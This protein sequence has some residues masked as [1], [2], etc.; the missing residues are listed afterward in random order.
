V[1]SAFKALLSVFFA[2]IV[3]LLFPASI[4]PG[5][6]QS[7]QPKI[8]VGAEMF[9]VAP[10]EITELEYQTA[11]RRFSATS[12]EGGK[13][14]FLIRVTGPTDADH[15]ECRSGKALD[16][17]LNELSSVRVKRVLSKEEMV[18][19]RQRY[20]GKSALLRVKAG[21][22][23]DPVEVKVI[24]S[25]RTSKSVILEEGAILYVSTLPRKFT[26]SLSRGC[27]VL[28]AR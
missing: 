2:L 3:S 24:R 16:L 7:E 5:Y 13:H 17:L 22:N 20:P 27:P 21:A 28:A 4:T 23:M 15:Q 14:G 18:S 8:Y 6:V 9:A 26:D 11:N 10:D 1:N 12:L 19:L 25:A